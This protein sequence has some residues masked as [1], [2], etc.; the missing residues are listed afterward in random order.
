MIRITVTKKSNPVLVRMFE[1][2]IES[3]KK[4]NK[5]VNA[6]IEVRGQ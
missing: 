6:K 5:P 4:N 3:L 1:L 2:A